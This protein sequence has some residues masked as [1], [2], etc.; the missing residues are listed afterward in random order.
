MRVIDTF[1][2][3]N[4]IDGDYFLNPKVCPTTAGYLVAWEQYNTRLWIA[5][6]NGDSLEQR[7][8]IDVESADILFFKY[9]DIGIYLLANNVL[10]GVDL[11]F[12][13][14]H[15]Q[16]IGTYKYKTIHTLLDFYSEGNG[17]YFFEYNH[18]FETLY[19]QHTESNW[20][21][22]TNVATFI[23]VYDEPDIYMNGQD[24]LMIWMDQQ[25]YVRVARA[26]IGTESTAKLVE[27]R[28]TD[29]GQLVSAVYEN[30]VMFGTCYKD[31]FVIQFY[32]FNSGALSNTISYKC[33]DYSRSELK[34]SVYDGLFMLM[35]D[36]DYTTEFRYF[37]KYGEMVENE[38]DDPYVE[39]DGEA[40]Y[41]E[42]DTGCK[43]DEL[44]ICGVVDLSMTFTMF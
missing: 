30:I 37:N 15:G 41:W 23:N 17:V 8:S 20:N 38:G 3:E 1:Q 31:E 4:N 29:G 10:N 7:I 33:D 22:S 44:A 27:V 39:C 36:N 16:V 5:C 12:I 25:N 43:K 18:E 11:Y 34:L 32:D 21:K 35:I 9:Y 2:T 19:V 24:F 14:T 26:F 13:S 42:I 40:I 6:Y 28:Q